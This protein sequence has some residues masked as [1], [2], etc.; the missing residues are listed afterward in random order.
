MSQ[1]ELQIQKDALLKAAINELKAIK[2][3]IEY[4]NDIMIDSGIHKAVKRIIATYDS[5]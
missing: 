4:Q 5:L 1:E 2:T 3:C